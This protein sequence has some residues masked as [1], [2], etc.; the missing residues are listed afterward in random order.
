M[1]EE[2][3]LRRKAFH[4]EEHLRGSEF[5]IIRNCERRVTQK[6]ENRFIWKPVLWVMVPCPSLSTGQQPSSLLTRYYRF[7]SEERVRFGTSAK[8]REL[9]VS[10]PKEQF[11]PCPQIYPIP[12]MPVSREHIHRARQETSPTMQRVSNQLFSDMLLNMIPL[13]FEENYEY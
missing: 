6:A 10:L 11:D 9:M 8:K 3:G 12:W 7:K 2:K 5:A 4:P 13:L 1:V